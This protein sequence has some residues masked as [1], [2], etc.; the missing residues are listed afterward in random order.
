MKIESNGN[1]TTFERDPE[2]IDFYI[3]EVYNF[4]EILKAICRRDPETREAI[5]DSRYK[6]LLTLRVGMRKL[7]TL[8]SII[9][10]RNILSADE[11]EEA[12]ASSEHPYTYD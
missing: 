8:I 7:K 12:S 4:S 1:F 6:D 5:L 3:A 2:N 9:E 10:S 11:Y